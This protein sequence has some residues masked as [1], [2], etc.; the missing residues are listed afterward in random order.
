M[1][2][3]HQPVAAITY[4][5]QDNTTKMTAS[6][7]Y[8]FL[9]HLALGMIPQTIATHINVGYYQDPA[10]SLYTTPEV[11]FNRINYDLFT[12]RASLFKT[13]QVRLV[14]KMDQDVNTTSL[15]HEA[16]HVA[17]VILGF[18]SNC[19]NYQSEAPD[20]VCV[21]AEPNTTLTYTTGGLCREDHNGIY[22]FV[23]HTRYLQTDLLKNLIMDA[24]LGS[25]G[26]VKPGLYKVID[27]SSAW[28]VSSLPLA[29]PNAPNKRV[30][31]SINSI[32]KDTLDK[33]RC[34]IKQLHGDDNAHFLQG[35][36]VVFIIFCVFLAL[37][38]FVMGMDKRGG[39]GAWGGLTGLGSC[40]W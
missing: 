1:V 38:T 10:V 31:S 26:L 25:F 12:S 13:R 33:N 6:V 36:L 16:F 28:A 7:Y 15:N 21:Q 11:L 34:K 27:Y 20:F 3:R 22:I 40:D 17:V 30:W 35:L 37:M 18:Q 4:C 29:K 39:A 32:V 19:N 2:H 5:T 9:M 23:D 8:L 14:L 24:L